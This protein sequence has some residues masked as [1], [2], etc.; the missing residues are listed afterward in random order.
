MAPPRTLS[1]EEDAISAM[2]TTLVR[3][4][5]VA[6]ASMLNR[7]RSSVATTVIKGE[8]PPCAFSITSLRMPERCACSP[9]RIQRRTAWSH[10][11]V[12]V[13]ATCMCSGE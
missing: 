10:S 13:P 11:S 6:T 12:F 7:V 9:I 5:L 1:A 8:L 2:P 4:Q 3:V